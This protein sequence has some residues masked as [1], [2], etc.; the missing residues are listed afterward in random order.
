MTE[1]GDRRSRR[2]LLGAA[3]SAAAGAV[4]ATALAGCG[5]GSQTHTDAG[6]DAAPGEVAGGRSAADV[7]LLSAALELER[8]TI[9]AYVAGIPLLNPY[10]QSGAT[11]WLAQELEHAGKLISLIHE[12]GGT[13]PPRAGS[14]AIGPRPRNQHQ[15]LALLA[16]LEHLQTSYYVRVIGRLAVPQLRAGVSEI[17]GSDAQHLSLLRLLAHE[18]PTS[19]AFVS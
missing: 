17:L 10:Q 3:A 6:D 4:A 13:A 11:V 7:R 19:T 2:G 1:T 12:V 14:Y 8:R 16:R 15:T 5:S 18:S 9:N